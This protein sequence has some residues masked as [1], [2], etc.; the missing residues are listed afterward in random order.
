MID[1]YQN[2]NWLKENL[3]VI[4]FLTIFLGVPVILAFLGATSEAGPDP[5][6]IYAP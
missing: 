6:D 1:S 3:M 4:V 5:N 2:M